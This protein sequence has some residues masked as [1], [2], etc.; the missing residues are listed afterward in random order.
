MKNNDY[1]RGVGYIRKGM[2][3]AIENM[4]KDGLLD[5]LGLFDDL[6]HYATERG[7]KPSAE[8]LIEKIQ[9]LYSANV[10]S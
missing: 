7:A 5:C 6:Q 1:D 4:N 8:Q 9:R 3:F 2:E 10:K